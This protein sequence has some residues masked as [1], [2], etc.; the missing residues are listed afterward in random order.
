[1]AYRENRMACRG[2][3]PIRTCV[4][5]GVKKAKFQLRRM[6]LEVQ[7]KHIILDPVQR[8]RG[9]GAY[10]CPGCLPKVQLTKR[11]KRA[12]RDEA[13]GLAKGSFL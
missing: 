1:M 7:E 13:R 11:L 4:V 2:H 5:C 6:V 8:L 10:V 12:F 9:R 3:V